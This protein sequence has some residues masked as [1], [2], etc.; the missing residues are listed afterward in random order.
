MKTRHNKFRRRPSVTIIVTC[1]WRIHCACC[2]RR[3]RQVGMHEAC[4]V[5]VTVVKKTTPSY[6][7]RIRRR[8][9]DIRWS[10]IGNKLQ[11]N[12][13]DNEKTTTTDQSQPKLSNWLIGQGLSLLSAS[14]DQTGKEWLHLFECVLFRQYNQTIKQYDKAQRTLKTDWLTTMYKSRSRYDIV[15]ALCG[16][17]CTVC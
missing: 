4:S 17:I 13:T 15:M 2:G 14:I 5:W 12:D 8:I 3:R 1:L 11:K 10:S 9:W 16:D 7:Y 6:C